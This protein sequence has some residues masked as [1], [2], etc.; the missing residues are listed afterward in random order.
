MQIE[1]DVAALRRTHWYEYVLRF[2]FGGAVTVAA[3]L[4]ARR[5]GPAFG[6]LFLAFPAI[7]PASATL[8]HSHE[9]EKKR[10]AGVMDDTRGRK[11]AA[12]DA[13]GAALGSVGLCGFATLLWQVLPHHNGFL[14]LLAALATWLAT[15]LLLWRMRRLRACRR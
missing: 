9:T 5:Y 1:F 3:G 13:R 15:A 7:F 14:S 11:A 10:K 6:G 8:V 2:A 12:L 4:I